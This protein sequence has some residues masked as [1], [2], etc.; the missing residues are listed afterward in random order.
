VTGMPVVPGTFESFDPSDYG[1]N[2]HYPY[3]QRPLKTLYCAS[4]IVMYPS[5]RMALSSPFLSKQR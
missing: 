2:T 4:L 5:T 3:Q 1:L